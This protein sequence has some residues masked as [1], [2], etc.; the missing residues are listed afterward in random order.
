MV[1]KAFITHKASESDSDCQDSFA[2]NEQNR[3][4]AV[5]DGIS[6]SMFPK[7]WADMLTAA[8]VDDLSFSIVDRRQMDKLRLQWWE[9]FEKTVAERQAA[10]DPFLWKLENSYNDRESAGSTFIG[11]RLCPERKVYYQVLGDSCVIVVKNCGTIKQ[12]SS[13]LEDAEFDNYPD[14][15]D[16]N[17]ELGM[18]GNVVSGYLDMMSGERIL[19][20]TDAL[21]DLFNEVRKDR[22]ESKKL[23]ELISNLNN[24]EEFENLVTKLR[25]A[26]ISDDDTTLIDIVFDGTDIFEVSVRAYLN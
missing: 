23:L 7:V 3:S 21:S 25:K 24:R 2:I 16:S 12:I 26:G 4:V 6:R 9:F 20:V 5:A 14:Y 13:K 8:F 17:G 15:I 18:K 1:I 11:I 19:L 22:E 10:N